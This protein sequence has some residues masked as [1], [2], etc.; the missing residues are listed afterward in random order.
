[1]RSCS[2]RSS[3]AHVLAEFGVERAERLVHQERLGAADDG[4]A[5][6]HALPVAAGEPADRPVEQMLD[7]RSA[8]TSSTA[9]RPRPAQARLT[10]GKE[11][12]RRTFICG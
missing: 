7:A 9:P 12:F 11:M 4:A 8:A 5:E 2:A 3:S 10:N 6:R 1:M